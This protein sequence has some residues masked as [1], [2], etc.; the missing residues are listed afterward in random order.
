MLAPML[1]A[2]SMVSLGFNPHDTYPCGNPINRSRSMRLG[3][4]KDPS[5]RRNHLPAFIIVNLKAMSVP[6]STFQW[7][8]ARLGEYRPAVEGAKPEGAPSSRSAGDLCKP[9]DRVDLTTSPCPPT[10]GEDPFSV[11]ISL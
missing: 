6:G 1:N 2:S 4:L 10:G 5:G 11:S 9:V 3:N 8:L 7:P